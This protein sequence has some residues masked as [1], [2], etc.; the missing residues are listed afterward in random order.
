MGRK[1]GFLSVALLVTL[2]GAAMPAWAIEVGQTLPCTRL[3]NV[4][5]DGSRREACTTDSAEGIS[6][7]LLE[8]SSA[9]CQYCSQNIP[10]VSSF[11]AEIRAEVTTRLIMIDRNE[12][13]IDQYVKDHRSAFQ[14]AVA[15]D[16]KR[17][18]FKLAGLQFTPTFLLLDKNGK[19]LFVQDGMLGEPD[20][21]KIREIIKR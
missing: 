20:A 11:A 13:L 6:F 9:Q 16:T 8:Y 4:Y 21:A 5:P 12:A 15:Y 2:L 10:F 18:A 7:T 17:Q 3:Q 19:V 14:F 1:S